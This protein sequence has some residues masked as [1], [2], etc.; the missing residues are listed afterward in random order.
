MPLRKNIKKF[1]QRRSKPGLQSNVQGAVKSGDHPGP[2]TSL[3]G[4]TTGSQSP[5]E[6]S[7]SSLIHPSERSDAE[8]SRDNSIPRGESILEE[9]INMAEEAEDALHK[10][11]TRSTADTGSSTAENASRRE[12]DGTNDSTLDEVPPLPSERRQSLNSVATLDSSHNRDSPE[13]A[14]AYNAIP[15]L[16]QTP[17]PRGGVS[18]DTQAVGRVQV[19]L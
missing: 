7:N 15:L 10:R 19:C 13:V 5:T 11:V 3:D 14:A 4:K 16:E 18:M 12:S 1:F 17:L 8:L 2:G 6:V 9:G